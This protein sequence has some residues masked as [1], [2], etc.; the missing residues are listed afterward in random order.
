MRIVFMGTPGVSVPTLEALIAHHEVI[1]VVTQP[2]KRKGRG[3]PMAFPPVK[4]R[5]LPMAFRF[6]SR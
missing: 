6:I 1:G 4:R 2:D 3:R 5:L